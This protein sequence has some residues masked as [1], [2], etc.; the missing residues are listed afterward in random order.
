MQYP[1]RVNPV[2]HGNLSAGQSKASEKMGKYGT[3]DASNLMKTVLNYP[4]FSRSIGR[5]ST[6]VTLTTNLPPR[7]Y[8]L[9]CMRTVWLCNCEY[10]W[11]QHRVECV[12]LGIT[13]A[14]LKEVAIGPSSTKL[15]GLDLLIVEAVDEMHNTHYLSDEKWTAFD[16]FGHNAVMDVM[17]TYG[18]YV[19]MSAFC[20]SAGV[21]L[22]NG[23]AGY[24][25]ELRGLEA[26]A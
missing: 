25:D 23:L 20:N 18:F 15:A 2:E 11:A 1:T 14:E 22:D 19:T 7:L 24:S 12:D 6:R 21:Q 26:S 9:A 13:D 4:E 17:T 16:Q 8:Q 10:L 5:I 3:A